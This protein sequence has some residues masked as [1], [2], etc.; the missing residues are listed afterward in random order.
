MKHEFGRWWMA[1]IMMLAVAGCTVDNTD[2]QTEEQV[3]EQASSGSPNAG[4]PDPAKEAPPPS[5]APPIA[6]DGRDQLNISGAI[7]LGPHAG[8]PVK[9]AAITRNLFATS[10]E[11]GLVYYTQDNLGWPTVSSPVSGVNA[12][13]YIFWLEGS[14]VYGGQYDWLRPGQNAKTIN[15][16]NAGYLGR[17]PARGAQVWFANVK[18]DGRERTN[19]AVSQNPWP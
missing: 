8:V 9:S 16:V 17:R 14:Q 11:N 3:S 7:L 1:A 6:T 15:N 10:I 2:V 12:R 4:T 13:S 18:V 5:P 19:V